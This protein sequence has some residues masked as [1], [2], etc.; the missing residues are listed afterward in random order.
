MRTYQLR[1]IKIKCPNK[2]WWWNEQTMKSGEKIWFW[3]KVCGKKI[4]VKEHSACGTMWPIASDQESHISVYLMLDG[5]V[6][7]G[8]GIERTR[9]KMLLPPKISNRWKWINTYEPHH[10]KYIHNFE[11]MADPDN[12]TFRLCSCDK[13][14]SGKWR[15]AQI[16]YTHIFILSISKK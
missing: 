9:T 8:E 16:Q 1:I 7:G 10:I 4:R 6:H 13:I 15:A 5:I 14:S 2:N 11:S 3:G 12:F